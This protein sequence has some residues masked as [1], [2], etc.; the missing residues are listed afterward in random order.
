MCT[1][2]AIERATQSLDSDS[3]TTIGPLV[4]IRKSSI[5][6]RHITIHLDLV[7]IN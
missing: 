7:L 1:Y 3:I 4:D 6:H 5:F 2:L